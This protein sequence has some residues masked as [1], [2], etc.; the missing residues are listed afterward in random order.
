M[1]TVRTY[2]PTPAESGRPSD[3]QPAHSVTATIQHTNTPMRVNVVHMNHHTEGWLT[4]CQL[5]H[6]DGHWD[7][8]FNP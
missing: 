6:N 2:D 8:L 5:H 4:D 7:V 1:T 3:G